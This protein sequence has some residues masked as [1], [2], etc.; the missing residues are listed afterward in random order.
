MGFQIGATWGITQWPGR[1]RMIRQDGGLWSSKKH[2]SDHGS[3]SCFIVKKGSED[4]NTYTSINIYIYM[5]WTWPGKL[6]TSIFCHTWIPCGFFLSIP[7]PGNLLIDLDVRIEFMFPCYKDSRFFVKQMSR[8]QWLQPWIVCIWN[9]KL[10]DCE[11][12]CFHIKSSKLRFFFHMSGSK[13]KTEAWLNF[14]RAFFLD[15][16]GLFKKSLV[17]WCPL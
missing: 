7:R 3:A 5:V 2:L 17:L 14:C 4:W 10:G 11:N 16:F 6:A 13:K 12:V 9:P 8:L 1:Y 15:W